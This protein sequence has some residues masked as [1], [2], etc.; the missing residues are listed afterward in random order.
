MMNR[1]Y[2]VISLK[3]ARVNAGLTQSEAATKLGISKKTIQN[4]EE[5]ITAPTMQKANEIAALYS[6]PK[7]YI[8]FL[9]NITLKA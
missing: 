1:K 7:D 2:P 8:F 9:D 6:F 3:A 5:G 4:Y